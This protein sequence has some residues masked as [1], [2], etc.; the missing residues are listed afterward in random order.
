MTI[1]TWKFTK[2]I[3]ITKAY[4]QNWRYIWKLR[5]WSEGSNFCALARAII[6][7]PY[8]SFITYLINWDWCLLIIFAVLTSFIFPLLLKHLISGRRDNNSSMMNSSLSWVFK[9]HSLIGQSNSQLYAVKNF[10]LEN[11]PKVFRCWDG[12]WRWF[13]SFCWKTIFDNF[14]NP[15]NLVENISI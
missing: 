15:S 14:F 11:G 5:L 2:I 10:Q 9:D 7:F 4:Y 1:I 13:C 12:C 8:E 3:W 6:L